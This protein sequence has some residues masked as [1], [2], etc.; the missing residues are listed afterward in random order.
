MM[1]YGTFLASA[2]L[3]LT[4]IWDRYDKFDR[5]S[6]SASLRDLGLRLFMCVYASFLL[7]FVAVSVGLIAEPS[8]QK[9]VPSYRSIDDDYEREPYDGY[10]SG[11]RGRR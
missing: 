10:R 6:F 11:G 9:S 8:K 5:S 2:A 3:T 7:S 1:S 4:F